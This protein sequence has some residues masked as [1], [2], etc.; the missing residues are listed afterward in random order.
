MESKYL[1]KINGKGIVYDTD[2]QAW[3]DCMIIGTTSITKS[4]EYLVVVGSYAKWMP[5]DKV[6]DIVWY[7]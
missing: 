7:I 2:L 1:N 4:P 6:V 5:Y 3:V